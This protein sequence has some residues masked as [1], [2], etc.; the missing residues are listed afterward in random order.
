MIKLEQMLKSGCSPTPDDLPSA[1]LG[2]IGPLKPPK[3]IVPGAIHLS[4]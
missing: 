2:K 3:K 1:S 4:G